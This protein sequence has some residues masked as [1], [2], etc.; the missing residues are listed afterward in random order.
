MGGFPFF[1]NKFD[2]CG[3]CGGGCGGFFGGFFGGHDGGC[4][5]GCDKPEAKCITAVRACRIGGGDDCDGGW[6]N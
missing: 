4:G 5:C 1:R 6:W 3:G 2:G